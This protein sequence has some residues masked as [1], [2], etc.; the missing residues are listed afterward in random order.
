[1]NKNFLKGVTNFIK[2]IQL[3]FNIS[4]KILISRI[5]SL[6]FFELINKF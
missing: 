1:M 6:K 5:I 4:I 2:C 3:L